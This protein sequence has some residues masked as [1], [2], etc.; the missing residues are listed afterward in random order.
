MRAPPA[1]EGG[2]P[3]RTTA[4]DLHGV[5]GCWTRQ[6]VILALSGP[7]RGVVA[8]SESLG[9]R[10][11]LLSTHARTLHE[12]G[13]ARMERDGQR[14]LWSLTA[15]ARITWEPD[16][17][18]IEVIAADKSRVSQFVPYGSPTMRLLELAVRAAGRSVPTARR[19]P[20]ARAD[21]PRPRNGRSSE[22]APRGESGANRSATV[23]AGPPPPATTTAVPPAVPARA[24]A[25]RNRPPRRR[26][27]AP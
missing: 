8:L 7:Q 5:L 26:P 25:G 1:E 2:Y 11:N 6:G 23:P 19:D 3:R 21:A 16:G 12:A 15:A 24:P 13:L 22:P 10:H 14:H 4:E 27:S 17:I 20:T 9:I 18:G